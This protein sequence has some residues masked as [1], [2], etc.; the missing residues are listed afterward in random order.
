MDKAGRWELRPQR[1]SWTQRAQP[2]LSLLQRGNSAPKAGVL[3]REMLSTKKCLGKTD[4]LSPNMSHT[5]PLGHSTQ[6]NNVHQD[7][8][9]SHGYVCQSGYLQD[10]SQKIQKT[11][12]YIAFYFYS[13]TSGNLTPPAPVKQSIHLQQHHC[14]AQPA[15]P[16]GKRIPCPSATPSLVTAHLEADGAIVVSVKG[17]EEKGG[18][19]AGVC[20]E[21]D[22][23]RVCCVTPACRG[24]CAGH[25]DGDRD[26]HSPP[27]GKNCE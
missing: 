14:S 22:S 9:F 19:R 6:E 7:L 24:T 12:F 13:T 8:L 11:P 1:L 4:C 18:I 2:R 10:T 27:C 15:V 5:S 25:G 21:A 20:G 26:G 16:A 3:T 17:V 23:K